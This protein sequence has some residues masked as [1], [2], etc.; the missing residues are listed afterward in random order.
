MRII[1]NLDDIFLQ[2]GFNILFMGI[3]LWF[4][5]SRSVSAALLGI[6]WKPNFFCCCLTRAPCPWRGLYSNFWLLSSMRLPKCAFNLVFQYL[7]LCIANPRNQQK[8]Q[9][10]SW[11]RLTTLFSCSKF[12]PLNSWLHLLFLRLSN[13][14]LYCIQVFKILFINV[15]T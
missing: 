7:A 6:D 4:N 14:F 12:G 9:G 11:V 8:P 13:H 3:S 10:E 1:Q 5:W 2:R 15:F